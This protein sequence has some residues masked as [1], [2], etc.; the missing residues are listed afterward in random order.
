MPPSHALLL[1]EQGSIVTN[2]ALAIDQYADEPSV[3]AFLRC[4]DLLGDPIGKQ[5]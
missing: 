2:A 5:A 1:R 3:L 4:S